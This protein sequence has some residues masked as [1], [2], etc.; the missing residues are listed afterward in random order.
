[1]EKRRFMM[2]EVSYLAGSPYWVEGV[3]GISPYKRAQ[4]GQLTHLL[5]NQPPVC[6][7]ECRR[8][9]MPKDRR[10]H[11]E[12][13][14][15]LDETQCVIRDAAEA[16]MFCLEISGE[17]EPLLSEHLSEI[18]QTAYDSGFT[19]TLI[20]NGHNLKDDFVT[21]CY[22]R[23]VTLVVSV[24]S[25][26]KEQYEMDN[27]L[28][29]SFDSTMKRIRSASEI[30]RDGHKIVDGKK[31]YRMAI[32]T[33][34]QSDNLC[35]LKDLRAFCDECGIFFSIAP[36][37]AIGSGLNHID[38]VLSDDEEDHLEG[39]GHNSIILSGSSKEEIG[40]EVCGTCLYGL[41]IGYDGNVL[42]DVHA[43]YEIGEILGNIRD[44]S[45]AELAQRQRMFAPI[46]FKNIDGFCPVRDKKWPTFLKNFIENPIDFSKAS[47]DGL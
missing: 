32:H 37:A 16:G 13:K 36:L 41:N 7:C 21:F 22:T 1:M 24:F 14:L 6:D 15:S 17:G 8:C 9:F 43:G 47:F 19:T 20:T 3:K 44:F 38:L 23:N 42:F 29:D 33:T 5:L 25:V 39:M 35:E 4:N 30:Y 31:V 2:S 46:I 28:S 12:G 10:D 26:N 34:V 40:R 11:C 27:G 45:I 18:I